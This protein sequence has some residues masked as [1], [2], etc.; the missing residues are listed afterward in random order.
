MPVNFGQLAGIPAPQVIATLPQQPNN[1]ADTLAGGLMSGLLQGQQM[2]D[3]AT[4]GQLHKLQLGQ[5]QQE[6]QDQQSLRGLTGDKYADQL[7]KTGNADKALSYMNSQAVYQNTLLQGKANFL[8]LSV[9]QQAIADRDNSIAVKVMDTVSQLPPEQAAATYAKYKTDVEKQYPGLKLPEKFDADTFASVMRTHEVIQ[10]QI[11]TQQTTEIATIAQ[12]RA[13]LEKAQREKAIA[14]QRGQPTGNIDAEIAAYQDK[15]KPKSETGTPSD[16]KK[17]MD[18][19]NAETDPEKKAILKQGLDKSIT[20]TKLVTD[21]V[22]AELA[23]LSSGE[24]QRYAKES[25]DSDNML[26]TSQS[27]RQLNRNF[28]SGF[29]SATKLQI[30]QA[31]EAITGKPLKDTAYGEALQSASMDFIMKRIQ[32]TKGAISEK[33][34]DAF[35]KASPGMRNSQAGNEKILNI[36]DATEMRK[37]EKADMARDY[38]ETNRTMKGFGK[39]WDAYVKANPIID[40]KTL[41]IINPKY[42]TQD[43]S[44]TQP[45]GTYVEG[46]VYQ[47]ANGNKAKYVNGKWESI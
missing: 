39:E 9:K 26:A 32:G 6:V 28:K 22:D 35:S 13:G 43:T 14:Q 27:F 29:G 38:Y 34:M 41:E 37:K 16:T 40:P 47:D 18:E 21:P 10:S 7:I 3:N 42:K 25:E 36:L 46:K 1:Q 30:A 31:Y 23:K 4:V 19:Y 44:A 17:R 45:S 15:L 33:E 24:V 8:D 20:P 5:A 11:Q 2:T 12:A